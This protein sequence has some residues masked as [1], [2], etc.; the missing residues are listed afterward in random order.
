ME[1][2]EG[3]SYTLTFTL[4]FPHKQDTVSFERIYDNYNFGPTTS[5][6]PIMQFSTLSSGIPCSLLPISLLRPRGRSC[7]VLLQFHQ[8]T[9]PKIWRVPYRFQN[10]WNDIKT[11]AK[12]EIVVLI[13]IERHGKELATV[14][15]KYCRLHSFLSANTALEMPLHWPWSPPVTFPKSKTQKSM[16]SLNTASW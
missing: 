13:W 16:I 15:P 8:L 7:Q 5:T 11:P 14:L 4:S 10:L 1:E 12:N 9:L 6:F 3:P 2:E